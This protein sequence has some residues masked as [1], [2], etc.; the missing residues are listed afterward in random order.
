MAKE[1]ILIVDD[2]GIITNELQG[3]EAGDYKI[4]TFHFDLFKV[5]SDKLISN[6]NKLLQS[7]MSKIESTKPKYIC[8]KS[9]YS[10]KNMMGDVLYSIHDILSNSMAIDITKLLKLENGLRDV[11]SQH[12]DGI[13]IY[14]HDATNINI[15]EKLDSIRYQIYHQYFNKGKKVA[16]N[17]IET[18][19][20]FNKP[21][22]IKSHSGWYD[23]S[24]RDGYS[25]I[26]T[27]QS[28]IEYA[29]LVR[30][31][32]FD[33]AEVRNKFLGHDN[34]R[35][36]NNNDNLKFI[37]YKRI[38]ADRNDNISFKYRNGNLGNISFKLGALTYNSDQELLID[39]PYKSYYK[40]L[41]AFIKKNNLL[42]KFYLPIDGK[43]S[44]KRR[45]NYTFYKIFL[46]KDDKEN[47]EKIIIVDYLTYEFYEIK[48]VEENILIDWLSIIFSSIYNYKF[49]NQNQ[50][51][52]NSNIVFD[53]NY[54]SE[55]DNFIYL[56]HFYHQE[57][58]TNISNIVNYTFYC[59]TFEKP[60]YLGEEEVKYIGNYIYNNITPLI[61]SKATDVVF[62]LLLN[63]VKQQARRASY[64]AVMARN[65]S[66]NI[67][68]HV[69]NTLSLMDKIH[70]FLNHDSFIQ[71]DSTNYT[72]PRK[73]YTLS[74]IWRTDDPNELRKFENKTLIS[75]F[76]D[77]LK[78]RMD[79]IADIATT[80]ET[81]FYNNR[82]IF[83]DVFRSFENNLLLL[84]NISGKEDKFRYT[85][86][87]TLNGKEC[88][89]DR[90]VSMPN[91]TLGN[92]AFYIMLE[93]IIRNTAKH[94]GCGEVVFTINIEDN[95]YNDFHRVAV[96]DDVHFPNEK[97]M[98]DFIH[99]RNLDIARNL[100]DENNEIRKNGWGTI[101][102]KIAACYLSGVSTAEMDNPE[103]RPIGIHKYKKLLK[104]CGSDTRK[105]I[106]NWKEYLHES[107]EQEGVFPSKLIRKTNKG[108]FIPILQAVREGDKDNCGFGYSFLIRKPKE[109][110][111]IQD[112]TLD[113]V[114]KKSNLNEI[115]I[116]VINEAAI[117]KYPHKYL[118]YY[119]REFNCADIK[120]QYYSLFKGNLPQQVYVCNSKKE[121]FYIDY[122]SGNAT[123]YSNEYDLQNL[124]KYDTYDSLF[125]LR[126]YNPLNKAFMDSNS[127]F[128]YIDN[129]N[130]PKIDHKEYVI[131]SHHGEGIEN[132]VF[133]ESEYIEFYGSSSIL[134]YMFE[135]LKRNTS[136]RDE[137]TYQKFNMNAFFVRG[138]NTEI[139]V[140]DERIQSV[141]KYTGYTVEAGWENKNISYE[142]IFAKTKIKVPSTDQFNLNDTDLYLKRKDILEYI[143]QESRKAEYII[144]HFGIIE[145]LRKGK[146]KA[147]EK[148]VQEIVADILK[149]TNMYNCKLI[150]TSGRGYTPDVMDLKEYFLP[151]SLLSNALLE[152]STRS[153]AHFVQL[154]N[155]LRK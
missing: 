27:R 86:K 90:L 57:D 35:T 110:L 51:W 83:S 50:E 155:S 144:I 53:R 99:S 65:Q 69:L 122:K 54:I 96:Y 82:Y 75:I 130:T 97:E 22:I 30:E 14:T 129:S 146:E 25:K 133:E 101:E 4:E 46:Q 107:T 117:T 80:S 100:L 64:A 24:V 94:S 131:I 58:S 127:D 154:L 31:I 2:I 28:L 73:I 88:G 81:G 43:K 23:R 7:L 45:I 10:V 116:Q 134:G 152:K 145:S 39:I 149:V 126:L 15:Y 123:K 118:L 125:R 61:I 79:F 71:K 17:Y 34:I 102:L 41:D 12:S 148:T 121:L 91:D 70:E 153:K 137:E 72:S 3:K 98:Y 108:T 124:L 16:V 77:Y 95:I 19:S 78:K 140:I 18:S 47:V 6:E 52:D 11:I 20:F 66:H 8:F 40:Q 115:G 84:H 56:F 104:D 105:F 150:V 147:E 111:I 151:Y 120:S 85:F 55:E 139:I 138:I 59:D 48:K 103:Y 113:I 136:D 132:N 13:L 9:D 26:G 68:S 135:N 1:T 21:R 49:L 87:L 32:A 128:K 93:N 60:E 114:E 29:E 33:F 74:R 42:D 44:P 141:L 142:K 112:G 38:I 5:Y 92:Q 106:Q 63:Q 89:S 36:F 37:R 67:G 143:Q 76:N 109:L 119:Y 62:P